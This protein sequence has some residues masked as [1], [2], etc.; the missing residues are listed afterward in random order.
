MSKRGPE[1]YMKRQK[2]LKRK[3]KAMEKLARRQAKKLQKAEGI[4]AAEEETGIPVEEQAAQE[5]EPQPL[6]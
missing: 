6:E 5:Q 4:P 3:Q 1:S 2:E